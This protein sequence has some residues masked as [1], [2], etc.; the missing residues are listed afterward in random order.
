MAKEQI[1][2]SSDS[3]RIDADPGTV[4]GELPKPMRWILER[5]SWKSLVAAEAAIVGAA[6]TLEIYGVDDAFK[7]SGS[8]LIVLALLAAGATVYVLEK[9]DENQR[10][11]SDLAKLRETLRLRA[12]VIHLEAEVAELKGEFV[13]WPKTRAQADNYRSTANTFHEGRGVFAKRAVPYRRAATDLFIV[14]LMLAV[15]GTLVSQFGGVRL[16]L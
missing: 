11:A 3:Y 16:P 5:R 7:S 14:E 1:G 12:D 9:L 2:N 13:D 6:T 10:L 4:S 8:L 15:C